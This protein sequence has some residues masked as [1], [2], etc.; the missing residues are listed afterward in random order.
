MY[1]VLEEDINSLGGVQTYARKL[2]EEF[3]DNKVILSSNGRK[4]LFNKS[5]PDKEQIKS[6]RKLQGEVIHFF[7]F[8]SFFVV[9]LL[10]FCSKGNKV[11]YTPCMHPFK[12]HRNP[13]FAKIFFNTFTRLALKKVHFLI[14]L[15]E[16]EKRFF[17]KYISPDKIEVIPVGIDRN[18]GA[19]L[20]A[21]KRKHVLF[22]GRDDE[23]KRMNIIEEVS[24][25]L[26]DIEFVFVCDKKKTDVANKKYHTK[27]SD[28]DLECLFKTA[29]VVV[30]PSKYESFSIVSAQ[31]LSFGV[32]I[33]ISEN[34]QIKSFLDQ[35]VSKII[36]E[37]KLK[38]DLIHAIEEFCLE[39]NT[40]LI[41]KCYNSSEKFVW[42]VLLEKYSDIYCY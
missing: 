41:N 19:P 33:I 14:A 32:P 13:L 12:D 8:S 23:N 27:I 26:P 29:M 37:N 4:L 38:E 31:A 40:E 2:S 34:V 24:A 20:P 10:L 3:S 35:D 9:F 42:D 5:L 22:V 6:V 25:Q 36:R 15:S 11:V 30:S 17:S 1:F 39:L 21:K 16:H 7:G 28:S 18:E